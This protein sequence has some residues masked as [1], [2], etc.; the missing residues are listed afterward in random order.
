MHSEQ[1]CD[2]V[3][4]SKFA[5]SGEHKCRSLHYVHA[6]DMHSIHM[7]LLTIDLYMCWAFST[8]VRPLAQPLETVGV[9]VDVYGLPY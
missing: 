5:S 8:V 3:P 4:H 7:K 2:I 1:R 9:S 6:A